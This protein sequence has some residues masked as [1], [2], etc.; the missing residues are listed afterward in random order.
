MTL[1]NA[2]ITMR[3][4][5]IDDDADILI[6]VGRYLRE[7]GHQLHVAE[8]GS[9]GLDILQRE[10]IDVV[11]TDLKMPQ[12][13]GFEVLRR[14]KKI[15]PE[16]EVIMI[17]GYGD[18]DGAVRA[19]REGAADFFTKPVQLAELSMALARTFRFHALHQEKE[20]YQK[21][22]DRL[23]EEVGQLFN[24]S[25]IIGQSPA[26]LA[27]KERIKEV[28]Q[29]HA[30]SVLI[31]GETG[32]GKELVARAI[33][34]GSARAQGPFIAVN[35]TTIPQSLAESMLFGHA[36]GAFTDA[37]QDHKGYF[38]QAHE[39]T[40]FLDEIGDMSPEIQAKLLRT[41]E[42]RRIQRIGEYNEI[43]VDVRVVSSTHRELSQYI[44]EGA[45]REDLYYRLNTF[46]IHIPPLRERRGD[47]A[48][49]GQHF[50]ERYAPEMRKSIE[51]FTPEAIALLE[52]HSFPGNIR[53]LR[54]TIERA[55]IL[56]KSRQIIPKNLQ[57][58][59]SATAPSDEPGNLNLAEN[60]KRLIEQALQQSGQVQSQAAKL[61]GITPDAIRRR[62]ERY[63]I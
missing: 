30:T 38:E 19:M 27:V 5:L 22:F 21:R 16:T 35:C 26:I 51:G 52:T 45:F 28:G 46:T 2:D 62:R 43:S 9:Q 33:H 47:I 11:I 41:L 58:D 10:T 17:T 39:G 4:L 18:I 29:T 31:H 63:S 61:L 55:A 15:A 57:F 40:L 6:S 24:P 56:C 34:Y 25:S 36:K 59:P 7:Q 44:S 49:L 60:E 42:E 12:M 20:R 54:N 8:S 53:E 1:A 14:I 13:D 23:N 48:L 32:T 3:V 50:L 37:R